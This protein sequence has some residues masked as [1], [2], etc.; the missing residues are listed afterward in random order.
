MPDIAIRAVDAKEVG[1]GEPAEETFH[2]PD[3]NSAALWRNSRID[4]LPPFLSQNS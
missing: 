1:L 3:Q 4:G 2:H